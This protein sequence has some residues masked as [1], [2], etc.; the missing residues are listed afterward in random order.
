[1]FARENTC[2]CVCVCVR[3]YRCMYVCVLVRVRVCV[4]ACV[5]VRMRVCVSYERVSYQHSRLFA[6][7]QRKLSIILNVSYQYSCV[8]FWALR[9]R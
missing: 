7:I 8:F 2:V 4:H 6:N 9:Q 3:V 5:C 1:M